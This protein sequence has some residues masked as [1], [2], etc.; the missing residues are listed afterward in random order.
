[1]W[2]HKNTRGIKQFRSYHW[3]GGDRG[4]IK[5]CHILVKS[6]TRN[7]C[8]RI[9]TDWQ[10]WKWEIHGRAE[11]LN[12]QW[13]GKELGGGGCWTTTPKQSTAINSCW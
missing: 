6:H 9:I 12:M 11:D 3:F 2:L 10:F 13:R 8:H 4:R 7:P 5:I 1:M